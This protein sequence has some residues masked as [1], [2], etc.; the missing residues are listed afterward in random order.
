MISPYGEI[1]S[2]QIFLY[3]VHILKGAVGAEIN[4][5]HRNTEG[6][7]SALEQKSGSVQCTG[8]PQVRRL[9]VPEAKECFL[10][11]NKKKF[12]SISLL[13]IHA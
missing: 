3:Y 10:L 8:I 12:Q 13:L 7:E 11:P 2:A 9:A 1:L 5:S 6:A 4:I